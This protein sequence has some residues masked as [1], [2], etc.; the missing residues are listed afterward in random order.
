MRTGTSGTSKKVS[1]TESGMI[2][3]FCSILFISPHPRMNQTFLSI[4]FISKQEIYCKFYLSNK[5][6]NSSIWNG[7]FQP[8]MISQ[9]LYSSLM[10]ALTSWQSM[11]LRQMLMPTK[12]PRS[13][14]FSINQNHSYF[15]PCPNKTRQQHQQSKRL[16]LRV[17]AGSEW[18]WASDRR[19][20]IRGVSTI[21]QK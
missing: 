5:M 16:M 6:A 18:V 8:L 13:H 9:N 2:C 17:K 20:G 21:R 4:Y 10:M 3:T 14:R 15:L 7:S 19:R 1:S 12:V 11:W